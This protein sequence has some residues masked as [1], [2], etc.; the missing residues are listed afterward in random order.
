[1]LPQC[2][3][4]SWDYLSVEASVQV[5]REGKDIKQQEHLAHEFRDSSLGQG[6]L[7]VGQRAPLPSLQFLSFLVKSQHL[8]GY[9]SKSLTL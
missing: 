6:S 1:M 7:A 9:F 3:A 8:L 2:S 5:Q 4:C